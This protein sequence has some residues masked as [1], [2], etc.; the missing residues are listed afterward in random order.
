M[1]KISVRLPESLHKHLRE[2]AQREGISINQLAASALSEKMAALAMQNYL[3]ERAAQANREKFEEVLA[4][5]P[6]DPPDPQ[7]AQV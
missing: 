2:F 1:S 4:E 7:D 5:V 3:A 6:N